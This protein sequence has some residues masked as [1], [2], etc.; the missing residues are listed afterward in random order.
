MC[1]YFPDMSYGIHSDSAFLPVPNQPPLRSDISMTIFLNDPATYD[2]GELTI[3][4]EDRPVPFKLPA[5]GAVVYPST[6][7]HEVSPVTRGERLVAITFIESQFRDER[8]RQLLYLLGEV[9]ALEGYN[10]KHEN[11]I[12]LA[13]IQQNLKRMWS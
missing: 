5:G 6:F 3:H 7:L 8:Q 13:F 2:G 12:R 10:I 1:K 11:R 4:F 9:E